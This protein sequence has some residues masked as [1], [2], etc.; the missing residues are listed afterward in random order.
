MLHEEV[1]GERVAAVVRNVE[2]SPTQKTRSCLARLTAGERL[3]Q[4]A[5]TERVETR[6]Q[7]GLR[8]RLATDRA[9][10]QIADAL[11]QLSN[12]KLYSCNS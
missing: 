3:L 2:H 6:Q 9:L 8:Q 4:A 11:D 7:L 12:V 5:E 10:R 1:R